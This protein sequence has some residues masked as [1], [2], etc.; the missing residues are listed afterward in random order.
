MSYEE[1]YQANLEVQH[2]A[3]ILNHKINQ[4]YQ[5]NST[6]PESYNNRQNEL[7][8]TIADLRL[9]LQTPLPTTNP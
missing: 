5:Q 2:Q 4:L 3:G 1:I 7:D 8:A 9:L 6:S